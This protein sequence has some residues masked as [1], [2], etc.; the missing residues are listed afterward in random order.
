MKIIS[1]FYFLVW[2][3]FKFESTNNQIDDDSQWK[4]LTEQINSWTSHV[5]SVSAVWQEL[6]NTQETI[7]FI[8]GFITHEVAMKGTVSVLHL[9]A[10]L[11]RPQFLKECTHDPNMH[12]LKKAK[13]HDCFL[14]FAVHNIIYQYATGHT[15]KPSYKFWVIRLLEGNPLTYIN[16]NQ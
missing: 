8:S 5:C 11:M 16:R 2:S 10:S 15:L 7:L 4:V 1:A 14:W 3:P 13:Q 12:E 9:T 6:P